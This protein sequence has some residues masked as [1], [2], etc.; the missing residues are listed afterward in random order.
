M[1]GQVYEVDTWVITLSLTVGILGV[2]ATTSAL[3]E[4]FI[5][6]GHIYL[7]SIWYTPEMLEVKLKCENKNA[8]FVVF[9]FM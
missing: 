5:D 2:S 9:I 6:L 7:H 1:L 3:R 4:R 8:L